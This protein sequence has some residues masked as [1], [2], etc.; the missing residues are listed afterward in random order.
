[1]KKNIYKKILQWLF[2]LTLISP[3]IVDR[4]LFFPYVTGSALYFR[5]I[6]ELLLAIWIIFILF[7]PEYRPKWN[8]LTISI[9]LYAI[10]LTLS[11]IFS[12]TPYLSFWGDAERMMG[13]FG[14]L[15]FFALFL[16]G[17]SLFKEKKELWKLLN[18]F[19][20]VSFVLC[21]YGILQRFGLTSIKPGELRI[22]ATLGNA[23]TFAGY[24]IFGLF[25]SL[26]LFLNLFKERKKN[27]STAVFI[28]CI[29]FYALSLI[30][31]LAAIFL[32]G[33]RGAYLGV[34][35]GL[36][37]SA[38]FIII[39]LKNKKL[40]ISL[41]GVLLISII[42]YSG[43]YIN[44]DKN[45]VKD[46]HYLYRITH[47]SLSD[48]T[49]QTRLMA[50]KWGFEG[51]KEKPILGHGFENYSISFNKNF[52]SKYY[53]LASNEYFD[54]AHNIVIEL[55]STTGIIG[56]LTYLMIFISIVY[57]IKRGYKKNDDYMYLGVI[58][59][60]VAAY[61][62]Q[63]LL[64]FDLL[65][66]MLGFMVLLI[67]VHNYSNND[68]LFTGDNPE[69]SIFEEAMI[70]S[71]AVVLVIG[72]IYSYK[73]LIIKP[74]KALIDNVKGQILINNNFD[75]G[76]SFLKDSVESN[77]FLDLD[78]RSSSANTVFNYYL[79]GGQ[80]TETM[81]ENIDF[82]VDLY[83]KNLGY[84]PYDTYYN[85]KIAEILNYRFAID[86]DEDIIAKAREYINKSIITSPKR[87][88]IYYILAENML[89]GGELDLAEKIGEDA[90][91]LND[92]LGESYWELAKIYYITQ[93]FDRAKENLQ[94]AINLGHHI[95]EQNM[96]GFMGLFE[97]G[98]SKDNEIE[99]YETLIENGTQNYIFYT[100]LANLY[101]EKKDKEN[102]IRCAK[103]AVILNPEIADDVEKFIEQ[104]SKALDN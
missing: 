38:V 48:S 61:F 81:K 54:R 43:F 1:M 96:Q 31:H 56:L 9:G 22:V 63:N 19:V 42:L 104:I 84:A 85:Y 94:K 90:V 13:L 41:A 69:K 49:A 67:F 39:K 72:L 64:I 36:F 75:L 82:V 93:K 44:R 7:C 23:G 46:N 33:T 76:I 59:G 79:D 20:L 83:K 73:N 78:L 86:L 55:M 21:I 50:W 95:S 18:A 71:V 70:L 14:M 10:A 60:L 29:V 5:A 12:A 2:F 58:I 68:N 37:L 32:T 100:T 26:Y 77:T 40:K 35:G 62:I 51:F 98:K 74:Y 57:C 3:L 52:E 45:F 34:F 27:I 15:H 89:M 99:Y 28:S 24:L 65:P 11:T 16:I 53:D 91:K 25:F 92:K 17:A 101:F 103:E 87:A 66:Q 30:A 97:I 102:A 80:E 8:F 6:V 4:R 47:F 88:K